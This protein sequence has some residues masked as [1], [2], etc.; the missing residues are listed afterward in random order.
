MDFMELF[1]FYKIQAISNAINPTMDSI[2]RLKCREYSKNFNTP[3]W[4]VENVLDPR[5]IL[6]SLE[7]EKY[8]PSIANNEMEE[9]LDEL[10]RIK[11]PTY[12]KMS[13]ETLEELVDHVL[14]K[15]IKRLNSKKAPTPE[16][17]EAEI[18][19]SESRT[20]KSGSMNFSDLEK[21]ESEPNTGFKD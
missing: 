15:E 21:I 13:K 12:T 19:K 18:K 3:L 4:E 2:W 1:E 11:D 9:L 14:N 7:E 10:Y 8:H 20:P 17:I 5:H 6:L 16:S